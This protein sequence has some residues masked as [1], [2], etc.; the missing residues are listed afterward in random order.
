M[1]VFR[2]GR[3]VG[4]ANYDANDLSLRRLE[5]PPKA[6]RLK[7][8]LRWSTVQDLGKPSFGT[9]GGPPHRYAL[10]I[11]NRRVI[12]FGGS[13]EP[14]HKHLRLHSIDIYVRD[15]ERCV[16]FYLDKLGFE[17]A[18]DA[19]L[20][21]GK[22]WVGVS[23]PD[24][25]AI[26][27]LIQPEPNSA[28]RK[29][30]GRAT[31][32]VFV[33]EDVAAQYREW[34]D[35]GVHF[36]YTPR[37][38]RIK[39]QKRGPGIPASDAVG[40]PAAGP[41]W[42]EVFT[43]FE[44][45]DGNSFALASFDEVTMAIEAQR[46]ARAEKLETDRRAAHEMD[47]ARQVQ[48]RLFPQ[49]LP[50]CATLEYSG[51]CKQARQVGGDYYDFLT[52]GQERIGL[53]VGD[54]AGKGIAA[55]LLMAN[56]QAQLRSQCALA[57]DQLEKLLRSVN[58]LFYENTV[59]SAYATLFFAEYND[60]LQRLRYVNCGHLCG[61]VLRRDDSVERLES[62][63]TVL[64]L[65]TEWDCSVGECQLF[66]GDILALYTDGVTE[67]YNA[68]GEEFGEERVLQSLSRHRSLS[69]EA[70]VRA[71]LSDV[72]QFGSEEQHDDITLMV[73]KCRA[74]LS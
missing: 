40:R 14:P 10:T 32:I 74:E 1:P 72:R 28:E 71:M 64:G 43:R 65:F 13:I 53:V 39:Y 8:T 34:S 50:I 9:S 68:P 49:Q 15:Q 57:L 19:R 73:A 52:L 59:A 54:V 18:F 63:C 36:R 11:Y 58:Q 24:G 27:T 30:I 47:I 70:M 48:A 4:V 45:A 2:E 62:T 67:S 16:R 6:W 46:R 37:L 17:L 22:R 12:T 29:L 35:R 51:V 38:R 56:L 31:R 44:D 3:D 61:L 42:G 33:S 5:L 21:S 41:I 55:A 66:A 69:P 26:L 20:H 23:P 7:L 25:T 60:R